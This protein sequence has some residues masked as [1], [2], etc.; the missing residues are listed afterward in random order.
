VTRAPLLPQDG[1]LRRREAAPVARPEARPAASDRVTRRGRDLAG[2]ALFRSDTGTLASLVPPA[3]PVERRLA[4]L[5]AA[6]APAATVA[7]PLSTAS[8]PRDAPAAAARPPRLAPALNADPT[9]RAAASAG[10]LTTLGAFSCHRR[11]P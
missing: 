6:P 2:S 11:T 8:A 9:V 5:E 3:P 4:A 1:R 10:C 7:T